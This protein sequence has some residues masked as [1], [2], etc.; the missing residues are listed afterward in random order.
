MMIFLPLVGIKRLWHSQVLKA[1]RD[2]EGG[3]RVDTETNGPFSQRR[4]HCVCRNM[5]VPLY[6]PFKKHFH[7]IISAP[8]N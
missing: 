1:T 8:P 3:G 7:L 5:L 4:P 6:P 2:Q